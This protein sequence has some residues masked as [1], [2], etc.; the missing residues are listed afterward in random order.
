MSSE[1]RYAGVQWS[2]HPLPTR[3]PSPFDL[4]PHA[5]AKSA[6]LELQQQLA[7]ISPSDH[8]FFAANGGKMFGVLVVR[9]MSEESGSIE[10]ETNLQP[11]TGPDT[12]HGSELGY[13][14]AF[15]GMLGGSWQRSGYAPPVFDIEERQQ[16]L[17]QGEAKLATLKLEIEAL[18]QSSERVQAQR[19]LHDLQSQKTQALDTAREQLQRRRKQRQA[20]R[21]KGRNDDPDDSLLTADE[22]SQLALQSQRDKSEYKTLKQQWDAKVEAAHT[23]CNAIEAPL[24][25]RK[26]HRR[27]LSRTLQQQLF[28]GYNIRSWNG[29]NCA[30]AD[31]FGDTLP[32][33]GAG[34]CATIKLLQW[35][36]ALGLQPVCLAE[37]WWGASPPGGVRHHQQF[38]PACRGK[39]RPI[40]THML[41]SLD[42]AAPQWQQTIHFPRS[43]P[44]TV[45]EDQH[46]LVVDKPAGMLSVAG[47]EITD[48]VEQRLQTR[49]PSLVPA[50]LSRLLLHRLDQAT[51]GLMVAAKDAISHKALHQQF[52]QRK[53]KKRYIADVEGC[54]STD[55][56][57][58]E[59]PLRVDLDD[60]PRQMVCREHG[61]AALTRFE[62]LY[63]DHE[64]TRVALYPITGRTHQLRVHLAHTEGLATPIIGDELYGTGSDRLHLHA[65]HLEFLH[66]VSGESLRFSSV[67]PF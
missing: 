61:K 7:D 49:Y 51:S 56:G 44:R 64:H 12:K 35:C 57:S 30:M 11:D 4:E 65:E 67:V 59:L 37:F 36:Y 46:I 16:Q 23:D 27:S 25:T 52:E 54:I 43:E 17:E 50:V 66:P 5:L 10:P 14:A 26:Q 15:S 40:L 58:I 47:K 48:S 24:A 2:D 6:G 9:R 45:Y 19:R 62:V 55:N 28:E 3:F 53:V 63:R 18:E 38:Y 41:N 39:C 29:R 8:D 32:P 1:I 34:D 20:Q 31:C 60:R 33:G 22:L 42:V 13:L 21:L